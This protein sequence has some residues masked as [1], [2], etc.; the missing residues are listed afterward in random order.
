MKWTEAYE[1]VLAMPHRRF[2]G[3]WICASIWDDPD[4]S[5]VQK[6]LIAEIDA[7]CGKD[8]ETGEEHA[9]FAGKEFLSKRLHV[10]PDHMR[11]ML[12]DLTTRGYLVR[13]GFTGRQ[14]L[15]CVRPDLSSNPQCAE[16]LIKKNRS[17]KKVTPGVTFS[18]QQ[19]SQKSDTEIPN[20][21]TNRETTTTSHERSTP[22]APVAGPVVVAS[23][24]SSLREEFGLNKKQSLKV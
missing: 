4:L 8:D 10:A 20:R 19:G 5:P 1:R 18:G 21:D 22:D 15:R 12:A 11:N 2:K 6:F 14:T 24:I 3:V 9:C 13:L 16:D 7:L 23:L 17:H